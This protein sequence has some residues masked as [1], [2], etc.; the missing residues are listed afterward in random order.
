RCTVLCF[1]NFIS[2][3][4][5]R[6]LNQGCPSSVICHHFHNTPSLEVTVL[7]A[8]ERVLGFVDGTTLR[9]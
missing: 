7:R 1:D 6:R 4:H 3:E 5:T 2:E 9:A 8:G